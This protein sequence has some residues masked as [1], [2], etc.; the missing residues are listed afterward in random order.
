M[1]A[2]LDA[3]AYR[4]DAIEA[5]AD[6]ARVAELEERYR[7]PR[8]T[9]VSEFGA[10]NKLL[11][12]GDARAVAAARPAVEA[13]VGA[14]AE[15][16]SALPTMLE[17]LPARVSKM[18]GVL[19]YLDAAGLGAADL[20]AVGDGENDAEM[21]AGAAL[22][23]A[24]GNAAAAARNAADVVVGANDDG[25]AATAL[26]LALALAAPAPKEASKGPRSR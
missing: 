5:L 7:E 9:I 10:A 3:V 11:L 8:A 17:V 12:L 1:G 21:L 25:G 4:G 15:V 23:V 22:G 2:G 16:T 24:V 20:V 19:S 14:G 18:T 26:R 6:T 13:A